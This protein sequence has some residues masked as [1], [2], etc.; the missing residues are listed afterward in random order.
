M[1][2]FIRILHDFSRSSPNRPIFHEHI[3][4]AMSSAFCRISP[5]PEAAGAGC[6]LSAKLQVP[7]IRLA[8]WQPGRK[9]DGIDGPRE[10]GLEGKIARRSGT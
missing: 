9:K 1:A 7:I 4:F 2:G 5:A 10:Q 3:R 6:A 8:R